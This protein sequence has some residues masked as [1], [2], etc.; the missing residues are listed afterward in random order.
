[1]RADPQPFPKLYGQYAVP[2]FLILIVYS[3]ELRTDD[4]ILFAAPS[5]AAFSGGRLG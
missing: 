1:M 3:F 4:F 5:T 2:G